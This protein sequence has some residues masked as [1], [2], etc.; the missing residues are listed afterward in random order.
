[1]INPYPWVF[2]PPCWKMCENKGGKL[3]KSAYLIKKLGKFSA[4]G[5]CVKTRGNSRISVD[6][7]NL[8]MN[9]TKH[10]TG[11]PGKRLSWPGIFWVLSRDIRTPVFP[12]R[13]NCP[14]GAYG[15]EGSDFSLF[16]CLCVVCCCLSVTL[17]IDPK[18]NPKIR[19]FRRNNGIIWSKTGSFFR[20]KLP[21]PFSDVGC[22]TQDAVDE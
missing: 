16:V 3:K 17:R 12:K 18:R 11:C 4:F 1:M 6:I 15:V 13:G 2:S 22:V 20:H 7:N 19:Q 5:G 9:G 21:N 8:R 10:M 14:F